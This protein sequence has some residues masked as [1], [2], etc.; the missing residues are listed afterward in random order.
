MPQ[1]SGVERGLYPQ[2]R[3]AGFIP[4]FPIRQD[5]SYVAFLDPG[6]GRPD[7]AVGSSVWVGTT[8]SLTSVTISWANWILIV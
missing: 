1:A 6:W 5:K 8:Q 7:Q 4:L 2:E 3:K